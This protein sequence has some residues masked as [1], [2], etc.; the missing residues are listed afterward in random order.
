MSNS[1]TSPHGDHVNFFI[2]QEKFTAT[3]PIT[4]RRIITEFAKED[5]AVTT[6]VLIHGNDRT[7]MEDIDTPFEL[8]NGTHF[9]TLH[10]GPTTV[11]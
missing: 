8:K 7:K 9:T 10:R 2:D 4:P 11:S 3:S 5:P 6:L 1:S